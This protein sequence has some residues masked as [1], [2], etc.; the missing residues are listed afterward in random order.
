MNFVPMKIEALRVED[1]EVY[2]VWEYVNDDQLGETAVLPV[3]GLPVD[4]LAG[5]VIGTKLRM[6]NGDWLWALVGNVD[7]RNQALNEQFLT[8]SVEREGHWFPLARYHDSDYNKRGPLA[9]AEFLSLNLEQV[10]PISYDLRPY[11]RG[12][13]S[14]LASEIP[15]EPSTKLTGDQLIAMAL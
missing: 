10:F 5:K 1:F 12:E 8:I 6:A 9:L 14:I 15:K 2:P 11:V 3:E 4:S 13:P 7:E